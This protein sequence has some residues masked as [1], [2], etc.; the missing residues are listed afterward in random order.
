MFCTKCGAQVPEGN[1]FCTKC[2]NKIGAAPEQKPAAAQPAKAK[3]DIVEKLKSVKLPKFDFM[4]TADGEKKAFENPFAG[5][6]TLLTKAMAIVCVLLL[7]LSY[8][9]TVNISFDKIP[10]VSMVFKMA[11]ED[12]EIEEMKEDLADTAE[13]LDEGYEKSEDEIK[14]LLSKS[15]VKKL[16]KFIKSVNNCAK[17]MSLNNF[18]KMISAYEPLEDLDMDAIGRHLLGSVEEAKE[19]NSILGVVKTFLLIGAL[20][21]AVF[22][23]FGGFKVKTGLAI[24][25]TVL[26]VLY[27]LSFCTFLMLLVNL[28]AQIYMI[29]VA[30]AVKKEQLA[31]TE[32]ATA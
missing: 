16:E 2:G 27:C 12:G 3:T 15:E 19:I 23:F 6:K 13:L 17:K 29:Y 32:T 4:K 11:D 20:V 1:A 28:A 24:A 5:N 14:E 18:S 31:Q 7:F 22:V 30:K 21:C 8:I 10:I 9:V 26:S 25:G